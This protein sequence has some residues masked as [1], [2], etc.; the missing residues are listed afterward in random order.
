[1]GLFLP[2]YLNQIRDSNNSK[3]RSIELP[4]SEI[5]ENN[6]EDVE[7]LNLD[8]LI[9]RLLTV[10]GARTAKDVH[11]TES[12]IKGLCYKAKSIFMSQPALLELEAPL[13]VCGK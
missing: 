9:L 4:T 2:G 10:K 13:K 5:M 3:K 12:E 6:N 11:L 1:M 7:K 8:D